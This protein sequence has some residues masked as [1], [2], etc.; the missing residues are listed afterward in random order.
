MANKDLT[1]LIPEMK[2]ALPFFIPGKIKEM[3]VNILFMVLSI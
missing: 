1:P 3:V 2:K